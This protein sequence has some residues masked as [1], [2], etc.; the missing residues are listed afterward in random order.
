MYGDLCSKALRTS[1]ADLTFTLLPKWARGTD[2]VSQ[3]SRRIHKVDPP[4]GSIIYTLGVLESRIGGS[5]HIIL[6]YAILPCYLP[7]EL[8]ALLFGSSQGSGLEPTVVEAQLWEY[9]AMSCTRFCILES[10][11]LLYPFLSSP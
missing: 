9:G 6:C 3:N 2:G 7:P 5:V 4:S 10:P 11:R 1:T 8:G